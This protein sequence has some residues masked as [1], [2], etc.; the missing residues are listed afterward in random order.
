MKKTLYLCLIS[1]SLLLTSCFNDAKI[2]FKKNEDS[3][4]FSYAESEL[5]L[6]LNDE[7]LKDASN[8][9]I[10]KINIHF[11][12][13]PTYAV[14][15]FSVSSR[16]IEG[17]IDVDLK[18]KT[19]SDVLYAAYTFL[20]K[21]GYL[22]DVTGPVKPTHFNW[23]EVKDY[24]EKIIPV[25]KKRGIRQ[26][27]N[28][29]MDLSAWGINE[30]KAYIQ[31]LSRMRFNYMTFHSYPGQWYEVKRKDTIE[32]AGN[33]FYGDVHTIPDHPVIKSISKNDKFFCIPEIEPVFEDEALRSKMATEWLAQVMGEA[34]RTGMGVQFSIEP[35]TEDIN[36]EKSVETVKAI[37]EHYPMI[38]ALEF[39][40]EESGGWSKKYTNI[41][42]M[43]KII[44][45]QFGEKYLNDEIITNPI[46]ERQNSLGYIYNQIGHHSKLINYLREHNIVSKDLELKTGIYIVIPEYAKPAFYIAR[47]LN[48]DCEVT[49]LSGHHALRVNNNLPKILQTKEDWDKTI[50]Y[51]WNELDGVMYLQQNCISS[52]KKGIDLIS[53]NTTDNRINAILYNHWRTAENKVTIRYSAESAL[54]GGIDIKT[55]YTNYAKSYGVGAEENFAK[56]MSILDLADQTVL[57]KVGGI[58]FCW[59]GRWKKGRRI[60]TYPLENLEATRLVY[61]RALKA[62]KPSV[63]VTTNKDGRNLL[64]FL[65]NRIRTAI[66]YLKAFEKATE[67]DK[68]HSKDTLSEEDKKEYT[69]IANET[70]ALFEQYIDVYAQINADRGCAGNIISLWHGPIRGTKILRNTYAG[71]PFDDEIPEGTAV[72]EPPLPQINTEEYK[73]N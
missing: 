73:P 32:Y 62:L 5:K 52:V 51:S 54:K 4:I 9:G 29:T 24:K 2:S 68:Y 53:K 30:A 18:G 69:R 19:P 42:Q 39:I 12:T 55:F 45:D 38:D 72:D 1:L 56:A 67:L 35:R 27:I 6:F 34:K 59:V 33:F 49:V 44:K 23:S 61:E 47:K 40:T 17:N 71:V 20:E 48:P 70:L 11:Q 63:S 46:R 36:P 26:H 43:K 21:G 65:D 50:F 58:G 16:N 25:A 57:D 22:F 60:S 31:N 14:A 13:E 64:A 41:P 66:I 37:L 3:T 28:F 8:S 15:E 7:F 10:D